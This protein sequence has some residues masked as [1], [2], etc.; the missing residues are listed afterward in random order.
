MD[1]FK[2][3]FSKINR[4]G[5]TPALNIDDGEFL[6]T[7]GV[8]EEYR[9]ESD[10]F[11]IPAGVTSIANHGTCI[12]KQTIDTVFIPKTVVHIGDSALMF[13]ETV[14]Y[15]GSESEWKFIQILE[16][17]FTTGWRP[18]WCSEPPID[19]YRVESVSFHYGIK[20]PWRE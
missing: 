19:Q 1:V 6:I 12:C 3:I 10:T 4:T 13:C 18:D 15:E 7:D 9:G 17:N 14:Y 11:I 20:F 5:S 8:L 2:T 16:N